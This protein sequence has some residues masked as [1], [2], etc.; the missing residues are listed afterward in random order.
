MKKIVK[1]IFIFSIVLNLFFVSLGGCFIYKKG[2]L[3][4]LISKTTTVISGQ[5]DFTPYYLDRKNLFEKLPVDNKSIIF[6]GDSITDGNEWSEIFYNTNVKNR[7]I[8]GDTTIG[9][10]ERL[11]T[12][13]KEKPEKIFLMVG[14][15]DLGELR[16]S[17]STII[18]DYKKILDFIKVQSPNTKVYVE[19]IL[20]VNTK[21]LK[22][23][24][25]NSD[26][27]EINNQ[28]KN[29]SNDDAIYINLFDLFIDKN[30]EL[31]EKYTHDGL[32]VNGDGY[33]IWSN[34]IKKY[35]N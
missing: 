33:L 26:I 16:H 34:A 22:S 35:I 8:S 24:R 2:G 20:P 13:V 32:H 4:Y 14:T 11:N 30:G 19:S 28:L 7:G 17:T 25:K 6:L 21:K 29:I 15:N 5:P 10:M 18:D 3:Y 9:I 12:I 27:K 1:I 31:D 23:P